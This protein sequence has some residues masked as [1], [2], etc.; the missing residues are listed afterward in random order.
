[1]VSAPNEFQTGQFRPVIGSPAGNAQADRLIVCSGK[2]YFDLREELEKDNVDSS[3]VAVLRLEQFYP[4]PHKEFEREIELLDGFS[5][6][7]WLQEEP[8]NM[9]AWGFVRHRLD[10]LL[11]PRNIRI[12][13]AGRV[14]SASVATGSALVHQAEQAAILAKAI[15]G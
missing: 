3:T 13:Y 6:A 4:F 7:V 9:G 11:A 5:R 2:V 12:E 14:A 8:E 1:M 10:D 15:S